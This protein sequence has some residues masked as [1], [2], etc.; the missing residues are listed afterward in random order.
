MA[1]Y[2]NTFMVR[3]YTLSLQVEVFGFV[4]DD[5]IYFRLIDSSRGVDEIL[6]YFCTSVAVIALAG[7]RKDSSLI[8]NGIER[9]LAGN[10]RNECLTCYRS[11]TAFGKRRLPD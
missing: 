3:T 2:H 1:D 10:R 7:H 8:C 6:P 11:K 5:D 9:I 4:I